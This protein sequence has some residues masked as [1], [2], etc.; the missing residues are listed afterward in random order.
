MLN[1]QA[2]FESYKFELEIQIQCYD[3]NSLVASL[4]EK[5]LGKQGVLGLF[6]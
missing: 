2:A 1:L 6:N 4:Q 3:L 5:L